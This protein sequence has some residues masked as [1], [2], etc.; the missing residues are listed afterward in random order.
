[1]WLQRLGSGNRRRRKLAAAMNNRNENWHG[2]ELAPGIS[3]SAGAAYHGSVKPAA[4]AAIEKIN[5]ERNTAASA[6]TK[7]QQ[8]RKQ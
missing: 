6:K 8:W 7:Y 5:I 3:I 1:M 4:S 2:A